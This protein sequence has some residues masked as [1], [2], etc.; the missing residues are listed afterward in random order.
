MKTSAKRMLALVLGATLLT[1]QP[2]VQAETFRIE[3]VTATAMPLP[4]ISFRDSE[5]VQTGT[6]IFG[7]PQNMGPIDR[8]LRGLL[9]LGL[10]GTG[11][12]GLATGQISTPVSATLL[13]VSVIPTATAAT[14]YCPL[15]QLFGVE[16]S[17]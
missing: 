2:A 3:P 1:L 13:G 4:E 15:Y 9:A 12:Y 7:L 6:T 14:G 5:P 11:I 16:Y 17:F 10:A 8:T